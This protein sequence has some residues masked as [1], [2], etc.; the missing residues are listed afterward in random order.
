MLRLSKRPEPV[1]EPPLVLP[2]SR[3]RRG[4]SRILRGLMLRVTKLSSFLNIFKI[5]LNHV[6][7]LP[8]MAKFITFH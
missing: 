3:G 4:G 1:E 8:T 7:S 5:S 2:P 6:K